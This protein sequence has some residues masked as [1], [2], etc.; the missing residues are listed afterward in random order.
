MKQHKRAAPVMPSYRTERGA[1]AKEDR[2]NRKIG[3]ALSGRKCPRTDA[4]IEKLRKKY[5]I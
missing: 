4:V 5:A 3:Q 2:R 1:E